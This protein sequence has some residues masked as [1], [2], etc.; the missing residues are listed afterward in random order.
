M[1]QR[2]PTAEFIQPRGSLFDGQARGQ[3]PGPA[4]EAKQ[5]AR[6]VREEA[7]QQARRIREDAKEW[8]RQEREQARSGRDRESTPWAAWADWPGR[9]GWPG[10]HG[11]PDAGLLKDVEQTVKGF[12]RDL[13]RLAWQ[14]GTTAG[15]DALAELRIILDETLDRV[16]SEIFDAGHAPKDARPAPDA[17]TPGPPAD[18]EPRTG[19]RA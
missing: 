8:A 19:P 7:R 16:R 1:L 18:P 3:A 13:S 10:G 15:E 5:R 9:R 4:E 17:E 12:V 14:S 2:H 11:G 6:R